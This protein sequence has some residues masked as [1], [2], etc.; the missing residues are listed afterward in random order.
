MTL[1]VTGTVSTNP[2][3][4]QI[5]VEFFEKKAL[6]DPLRNDVL[7]GLAFLK[8]EAQPGVIFPNYRRV[9]V[10]VVKRV[11]HQLG[12]IDAFFCD[13]RFKEMW[14][15][16]NI[17]EKELAATHDLRIVTEML[18]RFHQFPGNER[19]HLGVGVPDKIAMATHDCERQ[20]AQ[21]VLHP[22]IVAYEKARGLKLEVVNKAG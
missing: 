4:A 17:G 1:E 7:Q 14:Q 18:V 8:D 19:Y 3:I 15:H 21:N 22:H 10:D 11:S 13:P 9:D 2:A 6:L 12:E 16:S 5:S 20:L